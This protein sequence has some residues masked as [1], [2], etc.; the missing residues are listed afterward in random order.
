MKYFLIILIII[1][2]FLFLKISIYIKY[3]EKFEIWLNLVK[4]FNFRVNLSTIIRKHIKID[5]IKIDLKLLKNKL[6]ITSYLI[7][8]LLKRITLNNLTIFFILKRVLS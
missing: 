8:D 1:F 5:N 7:K 2:V 4:L 3:D 6:T